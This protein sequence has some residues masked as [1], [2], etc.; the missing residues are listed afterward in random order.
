[1]AT[2]GGAAGFDLIE[3]AWIPVRR[4]DGGDD[5]LSLQEVFE[6]AH[7][8]P[9]GIR[10]LVG[11]LPTQEFALLRLLLA[12]LHDALD[13]PADTEEWQEL[14]E[15]K[16]LPVQKIRDYLGGYRDRFDLLHPKTP[17]MQVANLH[18]AKNEFFPLDRIVADVPN[19]DQFF[20]M[21]ARGAQR[22][23]FAEAARWLVHAHAYDPSG[24]KSGA[25]GDARVKNGKGYPLGVG[26]AGNLGG[27]F[28]EGR[29]LRETLLL[30]LISFDSDVRTDD[31]DRPAWAFPPAD[32]AALR[33]AEQAYRPYGLR[34]LYT[35]QGRRIRLFADDGG[36][37]GVLLCYGDPLDAPNQHH[38]EPM[39]A[40]RRSPTQEKK[41]GE[42][43][44]YMPAEHVPARS[45]WR[46]LESLLKGRA[47]RQRGEAAERLRP[48]IV[49]WAAR[50]ANDEALSEDHPVSV[51]TVGAKYGTQQSVIDEVTDDR[52][53]MRITLLAD[54][55]A[56]L[57]QEAIDA[58]AD[59]DQAVF[60][61]GNLATD[62]AR[63]AGLDTDA[64]RAQARDRGFGEL[65]HLFR[66]WLE[67]LASDS[68]PQG[69]RRSWQRQVLRTV[70][71]IGRELVDAAGER[72][73]SGRI[74][75]TDNGDE[76]WLNAG[77]AER[78]FHNALSK[79][80]HMTQEPDEPGD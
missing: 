79:A 47:G 74:I 34:D 15:A 70:A 41:R 28:L 78:R 5:E 18:T 73:W 40:W 10:R 39:T 60:I 35:W 48:G 36:V 67:N 58:A 26:W 38:R 68:S 61:L 43:L 50:L 59:A 77:W 2:D 17:F 1:M 27:V 75:E 30:N 29:D 63:A 76:L 13:G 55:S 51:R 20:T 8:G 49:E 66:L 80:L 37:H 44:V 72:A 71:S 6:R 31:Q 24:I 9:D 52:V 25:V 57:R 65:D 46:G 23:D 21:R 42:N 53:N 4:N 45:A 3:Q 7:S 14:W 33:G 56:Q 19:G 16:E 12:V 22:L 62:I 32:A 69:E 64:P 54:R 11:D